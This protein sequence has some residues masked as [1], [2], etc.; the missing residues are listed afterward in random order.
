MAKSMLALVQAVAGELGL[1]VPGTVAGNPTSDVVQ[2][3]ALMN[4]AGDELSRMYDW[5][6]L[7]KEY[8]F[9]TQFAQYTGTATNGSVTLTGMSSTV[10]IDSTYMVTGTGVQQD[11]FVMA[12]GGGTVTLSLPANATSTGTYTFGKVRYAMPSDYDRIVDRTQFDK[13]KRWEMLGPQ[14]PQQWQWLKSSYISTGPRMRFRIMGNYF[15]VWPMPAVSTLLGFEYLSNAWAFDGSGNSK[16]GF[17]ADTDTCIYPDRL[18]I[19]FA[20]LKYFEIKGFETTALARDFSVAFGLA[21]A[22][23]HG[24]QT[25]SFAPRMSEVLISIEQVPDTGYGS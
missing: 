11:T 19:L 7:A 6:Q 23:D 14:T 8:R 10:G 15:T 12:A 20:K 22:H 24:S 17:T 1:N 21:K 5:Q 9:N 18:M 13:S 3:L 16:S 2:L 4:A 25:L